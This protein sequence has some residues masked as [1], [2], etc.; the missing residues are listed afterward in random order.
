MEKHSFDG[1]SKNCAIL[2]IG[3][4]RGT[5]QN[6]EQMLEQNGVIQCPTVKIARLELNDTWPGGTNN[7]FSNLVIVAHEVRIHRV[8]QSLWQFW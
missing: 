4:D 3:V 6:V 2:V 7:T 8:R 5:I 1:T